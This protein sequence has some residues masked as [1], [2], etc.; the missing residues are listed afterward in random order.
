MDDFIFFPPYKIINKNCIKEIDI[1]TRSIY[2]D[3]TNGLDC[4]EFSY[5]DFI[6]IISKIF[7]DEH[8]YVQEAKKL[9]ED[10]W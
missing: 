8:P 2:Y 10:L 7:G 4:F 3:S 1:Q 5:N 9:N 6:L